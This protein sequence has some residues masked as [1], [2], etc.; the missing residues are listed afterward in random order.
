V[1]VQRKGSMHVVG[2]IAGHP[3]P[4]YLS[5]LDRGVVLLFGLSFLVSEHGSVFVALVEPVDV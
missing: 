5:K 2:W 1:E 3:F 4:F